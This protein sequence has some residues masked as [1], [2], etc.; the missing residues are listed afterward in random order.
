VRTALGVVEIPADADGRVCKLRW[1]DAGCMS[2]GAGKTNEKN[3][4]PTNSLCTHEAPAPAAK[5]QANPATRQQD[6]SAYLEVFPALSEFWRAALR[7]CHRCSRIQVAVLQ[8]RIAPVAILFRDLRGI[9]WVDL[10]A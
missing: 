7:F 5:M 2:P 6:G 9:E 8:G 1:I 10:R 3:K 4:Q